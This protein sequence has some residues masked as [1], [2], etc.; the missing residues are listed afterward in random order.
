MTLTKLRNRPSKSGMVG[1]AIALAVTGAGAVGV[2]LA[3]NDGSPGKDPGAATWS[4]ADPS[5][6][7]EGLRELDR[8]QVPAAGLVVDR[9]RILPTGSVPQG[10]Y[11]FKLYPG[12]QMRGWDPRVE[13]LDLEQTDVIVPVSE[14]WQ[15]ER[16]SGGY[17]TVGGNPRLVEES[18]MIQPESGPSWSLA[19]GPLLPDAVLEDVLNERDSANYTYEHA[20]VTA[21][22]V[23]NSP[24]EAADR[25][26]HISFVIADQ[27]VSLIAPVAPFERVA[28]LVD[29]L[30]E[31]NQ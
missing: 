10:N 3:N 17:I 2:A 19:T 12:E 15:V 21:L 7:A 31:A 1:F 18:I 22:V 16:S 14:G 28:R 20:G 27:W 13:P 5:P 29:A 4:P 24:S 23:D 30:V 25:V 26:W 11:A 6:G 8:S 9:V